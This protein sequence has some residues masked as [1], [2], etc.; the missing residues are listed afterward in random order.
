MKMGNCNH[1]ILE[2]YYRE[3]GVAYGD[4]GLL[5]NGQKIIKEYL[6][7]KCSKRSVSTGNIVEALRVLVSRGE[8]QYTDICFIFNEKK[9]Y[10]NENI[11]YLE[12]PKGFLDYERTFLR[13]LI[14]TR[15]KKGKDVTKD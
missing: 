14:E 9:I 11:E 8:L 10:L 1:N 13:E 7:G 6:D 4:F 5:E 3:D 12:Y 15:L 2:I